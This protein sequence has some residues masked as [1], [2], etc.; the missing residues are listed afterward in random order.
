MWR[1]A[2]N[3]ENDVEVIYIRGTSIKESIY[4]FAISKQFLRGCSD[5]TKE[6]NLTFNSY[7]HF[8]NI[9]MR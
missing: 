9:R 7:L 3:K 1:S 6:P 4:M 5:T 2:W 8:Q